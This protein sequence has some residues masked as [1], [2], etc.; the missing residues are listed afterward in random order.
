MTKLFL[1]ALLLAATAAAVLPGT[2]DDFM[3]EGRVKEALTQYATPSD[4]AGWFSLDGRRTRL[5]AST[6]RGEGVL[7]EGD[8][9]VFV[10]PADAAG[11][12]AALSAQGALVEA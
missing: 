7:V 9:R 5:Y 6:V 1:T 4:D 12:L 8:R 2:V 10:T 3:R 11:F